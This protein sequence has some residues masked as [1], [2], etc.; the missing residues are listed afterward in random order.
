MKALIKVGYGCNNHCTFCHTLDVR[1]IDGAS[2]EV[3]AKIDRAARLGHTMIVLSGGEV[4]MRPELLRWATRSAARGMDFGLVTNGRALSYVELVDKLLERRLKYVY[5]SMHGGNAKMHNLLVRADAFE[6]TYRAIGNLSGKGLDLTV[7]TVVTQQNVDHLRPIVDAM[8]AFPDAAL[9]FSMVQPKGGGDLHF[10]RL[11][12][13]VS[14]VAE[15]VVD[16]IEYGLSKT[17]GKGPAF[18]HDGIPFCHLPGHEH[19]Y[20]DLKTHRFATMTEIGEGDFFPVDDRDKVQPEEC[21]R[22]TLRGPCPGLYRGYAE[23]HGLDEVHAVVGAPRSNSFHYVLERGVGRVVDEKCPVFEDGTSPWDRGRHLF[24]RT[25]DDRI[26]RYRTD[27]RDFTDREIEATKHDLG[28]VYLDVSRKAA[29]DDFARDLVQLRRSAIC[30]PCPA[31][32]TCAGMFEPASEEVFTRDDAA[33]RSVLAGL[34]GDVLDVGCG[35]GVYEDL[36]EPLARS[37]AI[38]YLGIEPNAERVASLRARLPWGEVLEASAESFESDRTFDHVL[39]LRSWNHLRD[40]RVAIDRLLAML[41]PNGTLTIV[42]NVAFGLVR[43][44]SQAGKAESGA[45]IFEHYRNDS[46]ADAA[47]IVDALGLSCLERRDVTSGTSNQWMLVYAT[48]RDRR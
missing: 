3:E 38:R 31:K 36:F 8:L 18:A 11:I 1:H 7:N 37:G 28:Q 14:Y 21:S 29:P 2:D 10:D 48:G 47:K 6:E 24:I 15:R 43:G 13:K 39:I 33:V 42:D 35:E 45:A 46:A 19:R 22:C 17:R 26:G 44:R 4:T 20:D 34:R 23:V 40:P 30:E 32:T 5:L 9:K 12:P 16:A 41:K 27:T 25:G